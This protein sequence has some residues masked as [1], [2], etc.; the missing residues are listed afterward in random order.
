MET[1]I[2]NIKLR[3]L[4]AKDLEQTLEWINDDEINYQLDIKGGKK[5]IEQQQQ[6]FDALQKDKSKIV[7]A[8]T[9]TDDKIYFGN[10]SLFNIDLNSKSAYLSIFIGAKQ[11]R[12][13]NI[14]FQSLLKLFDY[15]I[16]KLQIQI[17]YLTVREKNVKAINLYKKL[18][19]IESSKEKRVE[20]F[21]LMEKLLE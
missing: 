8:I 7:F 14:A 10:I 11:F 5:K 12:G 15:C 19:F 20:D 1:K 9:S 4:E 2:E 13:K 18:G 3:F 6:W 17:L 16:D 21:I